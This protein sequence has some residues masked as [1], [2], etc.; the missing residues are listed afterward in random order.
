MITIHSLV[1]GPLENNTYI[2]S[3]PLNR[4]AIVVDPSYEFEPILDVLTENQYRLSHILLTHAHYDHMVNVFKLSENFSPFVQI[5]LQPN[6]LELWNSGGGADLF[7]LQFQS[8]RNPDLHLY[9]G[10][11]IPLG[12]E[13]IEVRHTPGHTPGSVIFVLHS[14]QTI[15]TGDLIFFHSV[16]RTDLPGG[17]HFTLLHSIES[18]VFSLPGSYTI[19]PGHGPS[20]TVLEEVR[21]NPFL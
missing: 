5:G 20:T 3:S 9:S 13:E 7:G 18:Q 15:I 21:N 6:D 4:E 19:L 2:L 1:L 14:N 16:G 8:A 11:R 17:D 10:Q 12:G